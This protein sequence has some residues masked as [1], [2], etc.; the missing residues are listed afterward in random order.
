MRVG[1]SPDLATVRCKPWLSYDIP[2]PEDVNWLEDPE[3]NSMS[4]V[5]PRAESGGQLW[6]KGLHF[7]DDWAETE[8][9]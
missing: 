5:L 7:V 3:V 8:W 6:C 4:V 9:W 1:A 2:L